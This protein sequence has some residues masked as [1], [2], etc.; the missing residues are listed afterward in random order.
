MR[1]QEQDILKRTAIVNNLLMVVEGLESR[2]ASASIALNGKWGSGKT[3]ILQMLEE[4]LDLRMTHDGTAKKYFIFYYDCWK[5]DYY[6]EPLI[7]IVASMLDTIS[8]ENAFEEQIVD[9]AG[10]AC[11]SAKEVIKDIAEKFVENKLGVNLVGIAKD[12]AEE[13]KQSDTDRKEFDSLYSFK[14]NL[15]YARK[16]IKQIAEQKCI[17]FIVDELDRCLP[18]YEIKVLERLHHL[19]SGISGVI[20]LIAIDKKQLEHSI[21]Q[22]F[23]EKTVVKEYLRKFID[24]TINIDAGL[25]SD[26]FQQKYRQYIHLFKEIPLA[27]NEEFEKFFA[28]LFYGID[29]RSQE[30]ILEKA[31]CIHRLIA[32]DKPM[33]PILMYFELMWIRLSQLNETKKELPLFWVLDIDTDEMRTYTDT[34]GKNLFEY[35]R[36]L[37]QDAMKN[38]PEKEMLVPV[39]WMFDIIGTMKND[40]AVFEDLNMNRGRRRIDWNGMEPYRE[41][42]IKA[43]KFVKISLVMLE[44]DEN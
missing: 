3:F 5:Y 36:H 4:E 38:N 32:G 18:E 22:I 24:F 19:F 10:A 8:R 7:A 2:N 6:E 13:K 43:V 15:D 26:K 9:T 34:I 39:I 37:V 16:R 41:E 29:I 25:I 17:V 28:T 20:V 33:D 1:I 42:L 12:I 11:R 31:E 44:G 30:K 23:G 40:K 27:Q 35:L 14:K 21:H